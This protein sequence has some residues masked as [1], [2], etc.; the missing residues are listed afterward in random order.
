MW[1]S[2]SPR[3]TGKKPT[4]MSLEMSEN[5]G[6]SAAEAEALWTDLSGF[7]TQIG[8]AEGLNEL[9]CTSFTRRYQDLK[10]KADLRRF[11][12]SYFSEIL[13]PIELPAIMQTFHLAQR[14]A[15]REL[16]TLD[17]RLSEVDALRGFAKASARAGRFQ[18]NRLRPLRDQRLVQRYLQAIETGDAHGWHTV[19]FGMILSLYSMPLRQGLLHYA[20]QTLRG[21]VHSSTCPVNLSPAEAEALLAE[22]NPALPR[23]IEAALHRHAASNLVLLT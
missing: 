20:R 2:F 9:S 10:D 11:L 13:L 21:L 23:A 4:L 8:S 17:Q 22:M 18:L 19:V 6:I 1:Y 12:E 16:I 3:K 5:S 14:S 15:Y 7:T